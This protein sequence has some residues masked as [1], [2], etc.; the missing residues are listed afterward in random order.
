VSAT[1]GED[2]VMAKAEAGFRRTFVAL[3][4][5]AVALPG[6]AFMDGYRDG[7]GRWRHNDEQA[8]KE[9]QVNFSNW[10]NHKLW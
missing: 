8:V 3:A 5:M 9:E 7:D 4:A 2:D 10:V 1:A 6:C